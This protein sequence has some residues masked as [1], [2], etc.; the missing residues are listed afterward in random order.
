MPDLALAVVVAAA[1]APARPLLPWSEVA[2]SLDMVFPFV[3][4]LILKDSYYV[5]V[6]LSRSAEC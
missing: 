2:P 1:L 5:L 4:R 6:L 3:R